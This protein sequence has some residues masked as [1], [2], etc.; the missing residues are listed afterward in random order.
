MNERFL[1]LGNDYDGIMFNEATDK[2]LG[3]SDYLNF[4]YWDEDT[5]DQKE[6]SEN[7]IC[8]LLDLIPEKQGTILDVACGKGA[9]T[10]SL[11]RHYRPGAVTAI[12]IS[13]KQLEAARKN[14]PGCSF[15]VMDATTLEFEDASFDNIICVEAAFHF[16]TREKFLAEALR[17]LK[18]GGRIVLSDILMH[19]EAERRRKYRSEKNF[20]G[21][22]EEYKEVFLRVGFEGFELKD[23]TEE[24]WRRHYR[25]VVNYFHEIFL[26]GEIDREGLRVRLDSTYRVAPDLEYY[27][28]VSAVKPDTEVSGAT[29]D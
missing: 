17:V 24:C 1:A 7:L 10:R 11:L 20:V 29:E 26:A 25:S 5:R 27:L 13:E 9:S 23:V 12:N 15:S 4:G 19:E 21:D 18:P 14:A 16:D 2:Y 28:L 3:N 8:K 22:L 6:A